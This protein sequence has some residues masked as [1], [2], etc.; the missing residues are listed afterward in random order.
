MEIDIIDTHTPCVGPGW[1]S[2][3]VGRYTIRFIES[4]GTDLRNVKY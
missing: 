1:I 2:V 3:L 4:E